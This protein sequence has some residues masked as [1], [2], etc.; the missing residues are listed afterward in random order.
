MVV[1]MR[2]SV[3]VIIYSESGNIKNRDIQ[4]F[5]L[6]REAEEYAKD[7]KKQHEIKKIPSFI[8]VKKV[9]GDEIISRS[10]SKK[11]REK[12]REQKRKR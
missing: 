9:E 1:L 11:L 7:L 3:E 5:R 2:Y 8:Q 6:R 10:K 4:L 12:L